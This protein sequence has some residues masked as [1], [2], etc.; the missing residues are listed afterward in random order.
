M[1]HWYTADTHFNDDGIRRFFA[2]PFASTAQMDE[3]MIARACDVVG[4]QDDFWIIG[5]FA[6]CEDDA[7]RAAAIATFN[8]LPGRKHLVQGNHDPVWLLDAVD[9]ASTHHLVEV[10]DEDQLFV[11]C[12]YPLVTW[13]HARSGSFNLFGHVHLNWQGAANQINVGVDC[14][15]FAPVSRRDVLLRGFELPE[16]ELFLEVE[17]V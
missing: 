17:G 5:D 1:A 6:W 3:A 14:W 8:R 16:S 2:R 12:H 7:G 10:Q 4:P 15:D 9:W 11:L 13:N